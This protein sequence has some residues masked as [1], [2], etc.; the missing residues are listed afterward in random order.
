MTTL[1]TILA[2]GKSKGLPVKHLKLLAGKPLIQWTFEQAQEWGPTS[3][4]CSSDD[5]NI[6]EMAAKME[7]DVMERPEELAE[8]DTPKLAAIRHAWRTMEERTGLRYDMVIDLDGTNPMRNRE[9]IDS[10]Y[11]MMRRKSPET[12]VSA[13]KSRRNPYFNIAEIQNGKV[14]I[15][16][17]GDVFCRQSAP[18]CFDLNSSI[19]VYS[20][21]FL[22]DDSKLS[23]I[24]DNTKL[25]VMPD[26]A[27]CDIDNELDFK[28]V[29]MFYKPRPRG[30]NL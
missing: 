25:Y 23:P 18:Q 27:F 12:I 30:R 11:S 28:I 1:I 24:T 9:D 20:R 19:Y 4:A 17:G 2:R 6:L 22:K 8:D 14:R 3:I 5:A 13:V 21:R 10:C 16:K 7:I 15:C 26:E 29:E